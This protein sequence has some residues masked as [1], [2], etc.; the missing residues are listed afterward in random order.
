MGVVA[1]V[2]VL[3]WVGGKV[4]RGELGDALYVASSTAQK[5]VTLDSD[6]D[7]LKD[8]EEL[9]WK[10]DKTNADTDGDGTSDGEELALGRDPRKKGSG[11]K[12]A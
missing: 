4:E 6:R 5:T 3:W 7:G 12:L 2:L 8:W 10:T 11:D 9:L 1:V